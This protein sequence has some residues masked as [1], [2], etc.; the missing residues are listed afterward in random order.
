MKKEGVIHIGTSGWSYKHWKEIFYPATLAQEDWLHFYSALFL[1]TEINTSFYHIPQPQTIKHWK[2]TVPAGFMFCTKMSRYLTHMK[3]LKEPEES[4]ERFFT[5]FIALKRK[6][7]PV[8]IQLPASVS[9]KAAKARHFFSLCKKK[10]SYYRFALEVRHDSWLTKESIS[11]MR[12][13][14]IA[15]V[16]SQS[17]IG[18][19]YAELITAQHIY[20]RFHGP[21]ALY[22]SGYAEEQL[23]AFG[24]LFKRWKKQGHTIWAFF[25]NDIHGYAFKDARRLKML[26]K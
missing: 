5:A 14:N 21:G 23:K 4:M 9:F 2:E 25:N 24:V 1:T 10:Y 26:C 15:F 11:L 8:L 16:I 13:Y 19:P 7:G 6:M 22:A 18:L 3:K 12:E 17:G 20:V